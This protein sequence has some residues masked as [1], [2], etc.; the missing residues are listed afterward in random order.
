MFFVYL[1]GALG[2]LVNVLIYQ[3]KDAKRLVLFKL[4]SDVVWSLHY[5]FLSAYTAMAISMIAIVR[6]LTFYKEKKSKAANSALLVFFII[7]SIASAYITWGGYKSLL[8]TCASIISVISFWRKSPRLSR[9][10]ALPISFSMLTYDIFSGSHLGVANEIFTICSTV[11]GIIRYG[12]K[13]KVEG[14]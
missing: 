6:E 1:F 11:I 4:A 8:P 7:L 5:F 2:I 9:F 3:Q 13:R 14:R 10:L 12:G